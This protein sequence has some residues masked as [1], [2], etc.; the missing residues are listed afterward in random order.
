MINK[1]PP[2]QKVQM[3]MLRLDKYEVLKIRGEQRMLMSLK[4]NISPSKRL[5]LR[6]EENV[7]TY[8]K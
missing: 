1:L 8:S 4:F 2:N 3:D 5:K 6:P 7:S